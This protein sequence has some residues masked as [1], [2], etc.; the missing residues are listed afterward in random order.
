MAFTLSC[1]GKKVVFQPLPSEVTFSNSSTYY[2]YKIIGKGAVDIPSGVEV[3]EISFECDMFGEDLKHMPGI[4]PKLWKDPDDCRNLIN[5]WQRE[6]KICKL[7]LGEVGYENDVSIASAE[8][9]NHG[10]RG[11]VRFRLTFKVD[12]DAVVKYIPKKKKK[13]SSNSGKKGKSKLKDRKTPAKKKNSGFP[14]TY[15]VKSGDTL[16]E[17][18]SKKY[19]SGQKWTHIYNKNKSVIEA[20]AKKRGMSSSSKGHWIFPGTKL[21]LPAL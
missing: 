17:I 1:G 3:R 2:Q 12:R 14:Q 20:T 21:I 16:W 13:S 4:N 11:N 10:A 8:M 7:N 19:G 18:A 15:T 9:T 6:K 5:K